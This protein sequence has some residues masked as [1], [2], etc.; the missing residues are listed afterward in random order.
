MTVA[1]P[2]KVTQA[3]RL[4]ALLRA[5]GA[6]GVTPLLAL[7]VIGS[8]R[9]AAVVYVLKA[10]GHDIRTEIVPTPS[11]KHVARYTLHEGQAQLGLQL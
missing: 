2:P 1:D 4:L 8:L 10:D 6:E 7:D 11:G 5:R 9:L 3:T